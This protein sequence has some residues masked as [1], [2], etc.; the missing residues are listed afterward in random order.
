MNVFEAL[1]WMGAA[2]V[3]LKIFHGASQRLW[4]VFGVIC[5][6]GLL[7]KH[8]M[9][10]FGFG[11]FVGLLLTSQRKQFAKPWIWLGGLIAFL[12]FLPNLLWEIH[13]HFPTVELLR[14]VQQS[15]RNTEM[16]PGMFLLV[17]ALILHPLAAPV[18]IAGLFELLRDRDGKGWRVLGIAYAVLMICMLTMHGR[19]YYPAPA[20]PMLFAAGGL[21]FERWFSRLRSGRW[22]R[23]AYVSLLLVTGLVLAPFAYFPML[24][25]EQ[26]MAYSKIM[27]LAPVRL[28]N[29]EMGP[30]PQI[31]ADQ[32]LELRMAQAARATQLFAGEMEAL[33]QSVTE[34]ERKIAQFKIDHLGELP[35]QME[36]NM[37]G[38]ERIATVIRA[39]SDELTIA[40]G[41]RSELARAHHAAG[42]GSLPARRHRRQ[43]QGHGQP[44]GRTL[45]QAR[46]QRDG[47]WHVGLHRPHRPPDPGDRCAAPLPDAARQ[48]GH[49]GGAGAGL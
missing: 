44:L 38:L 24:T 45:V 14:N 7:N 22:L 15:G 36:V 47:Q 16:G 32:E 6:V 5:G 4:L 20:Y 11:L 28:E 27:H 43:R 1:F 23:P 42:G 19:M 35:E 25:V 2:L 41:R 31:Y 21:V 12:I 46:R 13:R 33:K 39:K 34:W 18:W 9:L 49:P 17:Q 10:I 29:H 8:S 40:E 37:R 30:L 3:V 48:R 26:Y